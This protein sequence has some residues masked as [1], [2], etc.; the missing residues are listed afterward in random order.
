MIQPPSVGPITGREDHCDRHHAKR[1]AALRRLEGVQDD[2]LLVRLQ[3]AAKE[4]L[5]DP[6][7]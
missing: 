3:A 4:A 7:A 2:G 5:H 6:E 1:L